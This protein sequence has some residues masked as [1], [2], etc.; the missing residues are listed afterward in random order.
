MLSSLLLLF[1]ATTAQAGPYKISVIADTASEERAREYIANLSN[2]EPYK[3]LIAQGYVQI[4]VQPKI[5][6]PD[7]LKCHG[8]TAGIE[9][10][11]TCDI[12]S[13]PDTRRTLCPGA[14]LCPIFTSVPNIGKGGTTFPISS[15]TFPWTT[16]LHEMTHSLGFSDDYA[17]TRSEAKVY[18]KK[19]MSAPNA[20]SSKSMPND[21]ATEAAAKAD[22][23]AKIPWCRVAVASGANVVT[24]K[25]DG[26]FVIGSPP[27]P[28]CPSDAVGVFRGGSCQAENPNTTWRPSFCPTIMGYPEMGEE[29]CDVMHRQAMISGYPNLIP[30][31]YRQV[32]AKKIQETTKMGPITLSSTA[33][34]PAI[35]SCPHFYEIPSVD[36]LN[37]HDELG[38]FYNRCNIPMA[39]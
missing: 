33:P 36:S 17:Y 28:S 39:Q 37:L 6:T 32:I 27:P 30:A 5:L 11:A 1:C 19:T 29:F 15:S 16:M 26:K 2:T 22:C 25:S 20:Y 38:I 24:A 14:D 8:G 9:R 12:L 23:L 13:G 34:N 31:Y 4:V 35:A 10:L 7:Q 3:Q 21:Y 18:C